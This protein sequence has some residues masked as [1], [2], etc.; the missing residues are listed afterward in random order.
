MGEQTEFEPGQR[1]P[2]DG[3]YMEIGEDSFH[4]GINNPAHVEMRKGQ[5]FPETSNQNRKWK[6]VKRQRQN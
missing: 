5:Q 4:M 1:A 2:N 3:E 6:K